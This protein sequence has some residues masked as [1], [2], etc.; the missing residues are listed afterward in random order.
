MEQPFDF[1]PKPERVFKFG[2]VSFC[3]W[4]SLLLIALLFRMQN[5]PGR[6]LLLLVSTGGMAAFNLVSLIVLRGRH[7]LIISSPCSRSSGWYGSR[8]ILSVDTTA[9]S[10]RQDFIYFS[11]SL[12]CAG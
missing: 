5:W 2:A 8:L 3:V 9:W 10:A 12:P 6:G 7:L 4:M 11:E 1:I